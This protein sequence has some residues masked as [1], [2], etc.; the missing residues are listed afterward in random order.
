MLI[1]KER[2]M[3][4]A[5]VFLALACTCALAPAQKTPSTPAPA[6]EAGAASFVCGGVGSADQQEMKAAAAQHDLML[7]FAVSNGAYL[8][9]VD[10]EVS[11]GRG[12]VAL[13][14]KCDGP[15]MLIDLPSSGTWR[16]T[17]RANG[18]VRRKTITTVRG[19]HAQAS[20][21]WPAGA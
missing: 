2:P 18:Q 19:R 14:T 16:V 8:A 4:T 7:T 12:A 6:S 1:R 5:A 3:K 9:D 17:A 10:V 20:F 21:I 13:A 11:N 15:I